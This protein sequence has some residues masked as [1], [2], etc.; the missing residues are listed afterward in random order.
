VS[1]ATQ[2]LVNREFTGLHCDLVNLW[3]RWI[4]YRQLFDADEERIALLNRIAPS[5]FATAQQVFLHDVLSSIAR[6]T[7]QTKVRDKDNLVIYRLIKGL[8]ETVDAQLISSLEA[9]WRIVT[10]AVKPITTIRHRML[11]H[12]DL[13]HALDPRD[14]PCRV[15][16]A[17]ESSGRSRQFRTS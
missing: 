16:T 1:K 11:A 14:F 12:R 6:I 17:T 4:T 7:D 10:K 13:K 3:V 9:K 8:D 2:I 5:F 15:S